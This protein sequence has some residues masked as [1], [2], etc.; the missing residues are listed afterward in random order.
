MQTTNPAT[1]KVKHYKMWLEIRFIAWG[2]RDNA[3]SFCKAK[4]SNRKT[5]YQIKKYK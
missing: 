4:I 1:G 3:N 2:E 5:I